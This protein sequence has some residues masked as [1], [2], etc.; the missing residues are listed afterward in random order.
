MSWD[1][2]KAV[3]HLAQTAAPH[4]AVVRHL[5]KI[6][7]CAE[8]VRQAVEVGLGGERGP[9]P[10]QTVPGCTTCS[11][12]DFGPVLRHVGFHPVPASL[13]YAKGDVMVIG[14]V[15]EDPHGH[16]AMFD[17]STWVSDFVQRDQWPAA[18]YRTANP[19]PKVTIYR[20]GDARTAAFS[21][22]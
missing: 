21:G 11:A 8:H 15:P 6:G 12:K 20:H 13:G 1:S 2:N 10:K 3:G 5:A 16:M 7:H 17:G 4:D 9:R 14:P 18:A 22:A 19:K